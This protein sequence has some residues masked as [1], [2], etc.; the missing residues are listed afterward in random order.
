MLP[1]ELGSRTISKKQELSNKDCVGIVLGRRDMDGCRFS[2]DGLVYGD[3]HSQLKVKSFLFMN[4]ASTHSSL[5]SEAK[6][7]AS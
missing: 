1:R 2:A 3:S 7:S 6:A 5:A 4:L